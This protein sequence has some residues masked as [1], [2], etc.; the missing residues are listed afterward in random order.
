MYDNYCVYSKFLKLLAIHLNKDAIII[1][2]GYYH[3]I[4]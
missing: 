4:L 3:Q 2:S 1:L